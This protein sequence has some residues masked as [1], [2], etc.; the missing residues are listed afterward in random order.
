[1]MTYMQKNTYA[2]VHVQVHTSTAF[3]KYYIGY[4]I[5]PFSMKAEI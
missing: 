4:K 1:M 5:L 2:Y 3:R